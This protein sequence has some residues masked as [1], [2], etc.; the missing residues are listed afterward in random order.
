MKDN[1]SET[2]LSHSDGILTD[3]N[4]YLSNSSSNNDASEI[5]F[6]QSRRAKVNED[7]FDSNNCIEEL[8]LEAV[9]FCLTLHNNNFCKRVV[10]KT[11][12]VILKTTF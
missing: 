3:T 7:T 4:R 2:L 9:K 10:V 11:F 5:V 1:L 12:K 6:D 8:H